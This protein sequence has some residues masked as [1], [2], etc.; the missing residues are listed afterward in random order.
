MTNPYDENNDSALHHNDDKHPHGKGT[1]KSMGYVKRDVNAPKT[2][3]DYSAVDSRSEAGGSYDIYGTQDVEGA[4][5][6][7]SGRNFL[8]RIN[9]FSPENEYGPN[10]VNI[11]TSVRGQYINVE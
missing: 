1:G 8:K 10:S 4:F 3:F 6:G 9:E 2:K 5:K 7:E 11:D